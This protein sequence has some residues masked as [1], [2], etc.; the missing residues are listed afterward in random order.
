MCISD[1]STGHSPSCWSPQCSPGSARAGFLG[2][3]LTIKMLK[4][5][6]PRLLYCF[7]GQPIHREETASPIQ[8]ERIFDVESKTLKMVARLITG[9]EQAAARCV[10]DARLLSIKRSGVFVDW[11]GNW[12]RWA[13]IQ[14]AIEYNQNG[15]AIASQKYGKARCMHGGHTLPNLEDL[16]R[17]PDSTHQEIIS[18]LD[19]FVRAVL[20]LRGIQHC[21]IQDCALRLGSSRSVVLAAC[22]SSN[23]WFIAHRLIESKSELSDYVEA[24]VRRQEYESKPSPEE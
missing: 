18:E 9:D 24:A 7:W 15:I 1:S 22:C 6:L 17:L 11:L 19:S 14:R 2:V 23:E 8:I 20:V 13:T 3:F 10:M 12:T 4:K 16:T 21:T 5:L